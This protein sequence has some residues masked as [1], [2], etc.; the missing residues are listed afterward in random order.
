MFSRP[1]GYPHLDLQLR[2]KVI[3]LTGVAKGIG[4][5]IARTVAQE[6]AI[7]IVVDRDPEAGE[8]LQSELRQGGKAGDLIIA[9]LVMPRACSKAVEQT[10]KKFGRIDAL[11]NNTGVN[12]G[13]SLQKGTPEKFLAL[14]R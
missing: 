5:A 13:V 11:V 3:L 14:L 12:D 9:D 8:G 6:D 1:E 7:P 2:E 4:A 10:I